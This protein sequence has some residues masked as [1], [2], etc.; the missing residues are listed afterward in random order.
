VSLPFSVEVPLECI[1]GSVGFALLLKASPVNQPEE[2]FCL[3]VE[4]VL[5]GTVN[6]QVI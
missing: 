2:P 4:R 1:R 3:I 6:V 5:C